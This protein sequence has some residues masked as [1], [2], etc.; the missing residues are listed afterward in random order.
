MKEEIKE[1]VTEGIERYGNMLRK[2]IEKIKG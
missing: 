2:E 1:E